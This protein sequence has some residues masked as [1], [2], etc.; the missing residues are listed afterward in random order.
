MADGNIGLPEDGAGKKLDTTSLSV[1]GTT[2]Q[3]ERA[4]LA[5]STDVA[6]AE[7]LN[8][9]PASAEYGSVVRIAENADPQVTTSSVSSI[10]AGSSDDVDSAGINTG[11]T[12]ILVGVVVTASVPFKVIVKT[13]L[14]GSATSRIVGFG[15]S[16]RK[17]EYNVPRG[18]FL[19]VAQSA[20][21]GVDLFRCTITNL[22]SDQ[23][24]DL[25]ATFFYNEV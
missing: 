6:L 4:Q 8:T 13:V 10:A 5:G 16:D 2:V 19:T 14:N 7:V 24:A 11:K 15:G 1:G 12:G 20:D 9:D 25:Y 23:A 17:F 21:A 18:R 22:D 3:R